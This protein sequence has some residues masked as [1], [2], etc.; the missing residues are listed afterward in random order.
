MSGCWPPYYL[1]EA[2]G[3][4]AV[5][6]GWFLAC[7]PAATAIVAP[8]SGRLSDRIGIRL[9]AVAGLLL[10]AVSLLLIAQLDASTPA[11]LVALSLLALGAGLGIFQAPN[12]SAVM[13]SVPATAL[14]VAGGMLSMMRTLGV[15]SGVAVLGAVYAAWLPEVAGGTTPPF[16]AGAFRAAFSVAAG[17]ALAAVAVSVLRLRHRRG[18]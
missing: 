1:V 2:R 9:P 17:V 8:L 16:S 12:Q 6:S 3:Y 14:G 13:G 7:M 15:V 10:E 18:Q 11:L 4:S 5:A